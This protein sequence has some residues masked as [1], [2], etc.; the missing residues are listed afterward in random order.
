MIGIIQLPIS[1]LINPFHSYPGY[2]FWPD[3]NWY[4]GAQVLNLETRYWG[5]LHS[6][7]FDGYAIPIPIW[8]YKYTANRYQYIYCLPAFISNRYRYLFWN[9]YQTDTEIQPLSYRYIGYYTDTDNYTHLYHIH[10]SGY[11]YLLLVSLWYSISR[12]SCQFL[13]PWVQ[14]FPKCAKF[15]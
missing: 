3:S 1:V 6:V 12:P 8:S 14:K 7:G 5:N 9:S 10:I 15:C 13:G 11:R 2:V 4:V